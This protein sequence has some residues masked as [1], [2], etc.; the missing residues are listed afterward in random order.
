[1]EGLVR[2]R[3]TRAIG[4]K[5]SAVWVEAEPADGGL[6]LVGLPEANERET[7]VRVRAALATVGIADVSARVVVNPAEP[8]PVTEP[9][10]LAI[11]VAVAAAVGKA[12]RRLFGPERVCEFFGELGMDGRLCA[13]RGL[14]V[15]CGAG[16]AAIVPQAQENEAALC[17]ADVWAARSLADV[18]SFLER[19]DITMLPRHTIVRRAASIPEAYM[20]ACGLDTLAAA[21]RG[22]SL[23]LIGPPGSGKLVLARLAAAL[24]PP[25]DERTIREALALHSVAGLIDGLPTG[26]PPFRAPHHS[27]SDAGLVGGGSMPRPGEV[28]LAHGGC[29]VLDELPEFRQRAL[30]CLAS[31]LRA[32]E[33]RLARSRVLAFP[34]RPALVVGLANPCP[35]GYHGTAR[36]CRCSPARREQYR[37]RF[38]W[39]E[40]KTTIE[41]STHNVGGPAQ[42]PIDPA[43]VVAA[44]V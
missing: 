39:L 33:S 14:F 13:V 17:A 25:P 31:V 23:L 42:R 22:G 41:L 24:L 28:S 11:A 10:D 21:A 34:A 9:I 26:A 12:E 37:A 16:A 30:Q 36:P 19:G 40:W 43:A 7:R 5:P 8:V 3:T 15:A 44:R 4:I 27:V 20:P 18:L 29:L 38:N 6:S 35:C 2:V 32:G 1:M